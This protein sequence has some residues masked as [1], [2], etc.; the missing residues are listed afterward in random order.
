MPSFDV[1]DPNNPIFDINMS[2]PL[3][4]EFAAD[5]MMGGLPDNLTDDHS[6]T[7]STDHN[8]RVGSMFFAR[9]A[10]AKNALPAMTPLKIKF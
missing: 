3:R 6:G 4:N 5:L 8:W 2:Y 9:T 10:Q 7:S 1:Q